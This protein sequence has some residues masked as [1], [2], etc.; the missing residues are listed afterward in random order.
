MAHEIFGERFFG[1][2]REPAWHGLGKVMNVPVTAI[3]AFEDM[4]AYDIHA[5]KLYRGNGSVVSGQAI[6]RELTAKGEPEKV[7]G[8][9]GPDFMPVTP[10]QTCQ[11]YDDSIG[12]AVETIGALKDGETLFIST[13]L[14]TIAVKNDEVEMYLLLINPMGGGE[15][16]QIRTTPQRVVC[17]NTLT[18]AQ[19]LSAQ[20]YKVRHDINALANMTGWLK[21]VMGKAKDQTAMIKEALEILANYWVDEKTAVEVLNQ[22][23]PAP[24]VP[25]NTA[26][27]DVMVRRLEHREYLGEVLASCRDNVLKLFS[28]AGTGMETPECAGT[29]Y[30]LFNACAE[31]EDNRWSKNPMGALESAVFGANADRKEACFEIL[32]ELAK[33]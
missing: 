2:Q 16:V 30:G 8:I 6:V 19:S 5:E 29:A 4:G 15:A 26:P 24:R 20:C 1:K 25:R 23:Y 10:T 28:G 9:V 31:F 32:M 27:K 21:D 12:Q 17:Q 13:K 11:A 18:I 7:I 22:T 3:Q 33:V 14:P